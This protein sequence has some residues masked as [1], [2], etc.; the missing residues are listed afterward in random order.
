MPVKLKYK[1]LDDQKIKINVDKLKDFLQNQDQKKQV[2]KLRSVINIV[3][4][5][6][7]TGKD[8]NNKKTVTKIDQINKLI[9][10]KEIE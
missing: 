4:A 2:L 7:K 10:S 5:P 1:L 3:I 6:A 8:N 9:C